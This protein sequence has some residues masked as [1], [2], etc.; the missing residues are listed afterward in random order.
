V[1]TTKESEKH[2]FVKE[3]IEE[4]PEIG[5]GWKWHYDTIHNALWWL[6]RHK[7]IPAPIRTLALQG[8]N[9]LLQ[10][11]ELDRLKR[12]NKDDRFHNIHIPEDEHVTVASVIVVELFTPNQ[13]AALEKSIK[14][15]KWNKR[16]RTATR[17]T[18]SELLA[19]ARS[20]NNMSWWRLADVVNMEG[21]YAPDAHR[22]KLPDGIERVQ[23]KAIQV[24]SGLTA[25]VARFNFNDAHSKKL[26][27]VWHADHEPFMERSKTMGTFSKLR[28]VDRQ[29]ATNKATQRARND[30]HGIARNWMTKHCS[31]YFAM[32][33]EKQL[34]MDVMMTE[35]YNPVSK[36]TK[37]PDN[38]IHDALRALGID[39]LD[40]YRITAPEIPDML[41]T[42]ANRLSESI[43]DAERTWG[44][45]VNR[46]KIVQSTENFKG[47]GGDANH[48]IS[49]IAEERV[50]PTLVLLA[51]SQL[52]VVLEAQYAKLRDGAQLQHKKFKVRSVNRLSGIVLDSSLTLASIRQDVA[53]LRRHKRWFEGANFVMTVAPLFTAKL[54]PKDKEPIDF[55]NDVMDHNDE[56]F[57]RLSKLDGD[58]RDILTTISQLGATG[59]D[60]RT[61]RWALAVSALSLIVAIIALYVS[62]KAGVPPSAMGGK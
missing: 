18:N 35:K 59:T 36:S 62:Y 29:S 48:A 10:I 52:L 58:Y 22:T 46:G 45:I 43:I 11:N 34:S 20:R 37:R 5:H 14:K 4:V 39:S 7:K 9:D 38:D 61:G 1:M 28:P 27:D 49:Y 54:K 25:V 42:Q 26:D 24:G 41:L 32:H 21:Y 2:S 6:I 55:F 31:G 23:L 44:L 53:N 50:G 19:Q 12:W 60:I 15:N 16:S 40:F 17:E 56:T 3:A 30:L 8:V 51:I 47:F 33:G 13:A 57:K